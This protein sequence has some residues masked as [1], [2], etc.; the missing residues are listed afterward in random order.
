MLFTGLVPLN[1]WFCLLKSYCMQ[2]HAYVMQT[3][4]IYAIN[5]E[6]VW[7]ITLKHVRV[8]CR[9]PERQISAH[10]LFLKF[11]NFCLVPF[12]CFVSFVFGLVWSDLCVCS[13][14][15]WLSFSP[16]IYRELISMSRVCFCSVYCNLCVSCLCSVWSSVCMHFSDGFLWPNSVFFL[17]W[18]FRLASVFLFLWYGLV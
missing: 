13:C 12:L 9:F 10:A 5:G 15:V 14:L 16:M 18:W 6:S 11:P 3:F 1:L 8:F 17:Q 2:R 4:E 7:S